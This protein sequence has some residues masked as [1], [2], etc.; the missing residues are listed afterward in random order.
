MVSGIGD[1]YGTRVFFLPL[2]LWARLGRGEEQVYAH[3]GCFPGLHGVC[4]WGMGGVV[5]V[6]SGRQLRGRIAQCVFLWSYPGKSGRVIGTQMIG[7]R[8]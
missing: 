5:G 4:G 1:V 6:A 3:E 7:F 2:V 8:F